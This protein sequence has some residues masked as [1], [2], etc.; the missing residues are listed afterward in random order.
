MRHIRHFIL[1]MVVTLFL[2]PGGSVAGDEQAPADEQAVSGETEGP[3]TL[4]LVEGLFN[5]HCGGC[6]GVK[7]VGTDKGPPLVDEVYGP[8]HHG[9][10]SFYLAVSR[11]VTAHHWEFGDMPKMEG[12]VSDREMGGIILY[13]RYLQRQAGI[14]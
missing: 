2:L 12:V 5:R 1:V 4:E 3:M 6:H 14:D 11:G 10:L 8:D 13:V 7:G 9:D